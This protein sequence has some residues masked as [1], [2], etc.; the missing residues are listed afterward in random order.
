MAIHR[1]KI[2]IYHIFQIKNLLTD[3]T[4]AMVTLSVSLNADIGPGGINFFEI[5]Y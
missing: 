1:Q 5:G 4:D 3:Y 2:N